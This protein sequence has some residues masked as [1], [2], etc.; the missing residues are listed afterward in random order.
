MRYVGMLC[1]V[2]TV[3]LFEEGQGG[4]HH[5]NLPSLSSIGRLSLPDLMAYY[6]SR[7]NLLRRVVVRTHSNQL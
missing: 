1:I 2:Y 4:S 6:S 7:L 3:L 5:A